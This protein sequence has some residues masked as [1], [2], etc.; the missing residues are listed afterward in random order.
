MKLENKCVVNHDK[1]LCHSEDYSTLMMNIQK[2]IEN[3]SLLCCTLNILLTMSCTNCFLKY[4]A[5]T[6]LFIIAFI[7]R[8]EQLFHGI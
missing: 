3:K 8:G 4:W 7:N 2:S 5:G 1:V 6:F